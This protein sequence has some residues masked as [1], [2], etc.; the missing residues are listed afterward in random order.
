MSLRHQCAVCRNIVETAV[1]RAGA[2]GADPDPFQW[3]EGPGKGCLHVVRDLLLAKQQHAVFFQGGTYRAIDSTTAGHVDQADAPHFDSEFR[4]EG[5][6]FHDATP[7]STL[8]F[9][10]FSR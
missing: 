7:K 6:Q 2:D 5:N 9:K 8:A 3:G 10:D 1:K 4:P